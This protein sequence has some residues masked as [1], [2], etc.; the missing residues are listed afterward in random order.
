MTVDPSGTKPPTLPIGAYDAPAQLADAITRTRSRPNDAASWERLGQ[1]FIA[2]RKTR[3]APRCF[4][5]AAELEPQN[6]LHWARLG[7]VLLS[8]RQYDPAQDALRRACALD[9]VSAQ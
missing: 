1:A 8:L 3:S 9:P 4:A 7:K 2:A 6:A 5:R